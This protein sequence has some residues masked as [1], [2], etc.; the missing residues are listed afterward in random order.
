MMV[1]M[2]LSSF[3]GGQAQSKFGKHYDARMAEF[4]TMDD[5]DE[6]TIV[7]LGN[8]L[9]ENAGYHGGWQMLLGADNVSNRGIS[10]DTAVGILARLNTIL[11]KHPKAIFLMCGTNDLSHKLLPE[12]VFERVCEVIDSIRAEAPQTKLFVQSMLPFNE[13]TGRWKTLDGRTDD[14]PVINDMLSS[15]CYGLDIPF[16]NIF[17]HLVIEGTNSLRMELTVDGLHLNSDGYAI[18]AQ[19]LRPYVEAVNKQ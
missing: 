17:P 7:M 6:N 2:L 3:V 8:S 18:W 14:V 11:S 10:G 4:A 16:V 13:S 15:Y 12:Q 5:I 9:T 1:A 19:V